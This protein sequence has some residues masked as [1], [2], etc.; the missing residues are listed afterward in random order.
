M[1]TKVVA[2]PGMPQ[3]C[4]VAPDSIKS[5]PV[6][7]MMPLC[8][9][10]PLGMHGAGRKLQQHQH[11]SK[12]CIAIFAYGAWQCLVSKAKFS[13]LGIGMLMV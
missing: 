10:I 13:L 6:A 4:I 9:R 8:I 7:G 2:A 5:E 1:A 12:R 3:H 11:F